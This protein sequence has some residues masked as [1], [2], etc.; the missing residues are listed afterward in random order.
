MIGNKELIK[1]KFKALAKN[2][3]SKDNNINK[4]LRLFIIKPQK[5]KIN[6]IEV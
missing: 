3:I 2:V 6:K 1:M 4:I 5:P